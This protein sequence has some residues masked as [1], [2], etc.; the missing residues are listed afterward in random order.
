VLRGFIRRLKVAASSLRRHLGFLLIGVGLTFT[1]FLVLLFAD[2]LVRTFAGQEIPSPIAL[3]AGTQIREAPRLTRIIG[4]PSGGAAAVTIGRTI[5]VP[6]VRLVEGLSGTGAELRLLPGDTL[7]LSA[8]TW[9]QV[10]E[11]ERVH[12]AQRERYGRLY[13]TIYVFWYLRR[14]YLHHPLEQE[15]REGRR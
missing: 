11:H 4:A 3:P 7:L 14:G 8:E 10:I 1:P 15:A 2:E 5:L 6:R 9:R 12:V 13:L